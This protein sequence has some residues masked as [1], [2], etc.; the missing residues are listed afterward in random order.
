MRKVGNLEVQ[1]SSA[2]EIELDDANTNNKIAI[3]KAEKEKEVAIINANKEKEV[4]RTKAEEEKEIATIN[5]R[6]K[7]ETE[8]EIA[9]MDAR[10]KA[11][12]DKEIAVN[13][14]KEELGANNYTPIKSTRND[15]PSHEQESHSHLRIVPSASQ[16]SNSRI[17]YESRNMF[18][19]FDDKKPA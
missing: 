6:A 18:K 14:A 4:A 5:A 15:V 13:R 8:K 10:I 3:I 9:I 17:P 1:R 16:P 12:T 2:E 7:A 11:E 19:S